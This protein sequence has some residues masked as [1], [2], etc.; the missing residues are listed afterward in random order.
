M[1]AESTG[2]PISLA[3][4]KTDLA[5]PEE[6]Q[7]LV[8]RIVKWGYEAQLVSCQTGEGVE[9]CGEMLRDRISAVIGPSGIASVPA[10]TNA[11]SDSVTSRSWKVV[12]D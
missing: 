7:A 1:E 12:V 11:S 5:S 4:N 10:R 3:V 8:A 9:Q 2:V 6:L